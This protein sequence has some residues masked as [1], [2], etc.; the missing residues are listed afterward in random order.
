MQQ[1]LC[2]RQQ[3]QKNANQSGKVCSRNRNLLQLVLQAQGIYEALKQNS[4]AAYNRNW[5]YLQE[6]F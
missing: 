2:D 5:Q 1:Q 6:K 3:L 4:L